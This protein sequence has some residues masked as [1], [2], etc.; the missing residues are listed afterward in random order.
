[1]NT[2]DEWEQYRVKEGASGVPNDEWSQYAVKEKSFGEEAARVSKGLLARGLETIVGF[3]GE[4]EALGRRGLEHAKKTLFPEKKEGFQET[5]E[6]KKPEEKQEGQSKTFLPR[7]GE[8]REAIKEKH[9]EL[10]PQGKWEELAQEFVSDAVLQPGSLIRKAGVTAASIGAK[11][12]TKLLGGGEKAQIGTK[13]IVGFLASR[14]GQDNVNDYIN[15][16]Y[17]RASKAIPKDATLPAGKIDG[18]LTKV[19]QA[20]REGGDAPWKK[21]V[22]SQVTELKKNIKDGKVAVTAIDKAIQDFNS[23]LKEKAV[24]GTKAELW[25]NRMKES[26]QGKLA[27]YGKTNPQ[28]YDHYTKATAA[29]AGLK[30]SQKASDWLKNKKYQLGL[31][32]G[33]LLLAEAVIGGGELTAKT[34]AAAGAA[35]GIGKSYELVNR[36][37][38]NP[39]LT[40][41]YVKAMGAAA[42]E[43]SKQFIYNINKLD[44]AMNSDADLQSAR[45]ESQ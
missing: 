27:K 38:Q 39:T 7:M 22:L 33:S 40:K 45:K 15:D 42:A 9:P 11:E 14:I 34:V 18:Y 37:L 35:Y 32:S 41:Y 16:E 26:A 17:R 10:E 6:L 2:T 28:F 8:I 12:V 19:E 5:F 29:Y 13:M 31:S 21:H 30:Q 1:M 36:I 4:I 23:T 44:K 25:L 43:N 3:P 20:V 24:K